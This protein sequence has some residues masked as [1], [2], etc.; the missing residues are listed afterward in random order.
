MPAP[1][2]YGHP[3]AE[4]DQLRRQLQELDGHDRDNLR[5]YRQIQQQLRE[6]DAQMETLGRK[7]AALNVSLSRV[8]GVGEKLR[9]SMSEVRSR[10]VS[11]ERSGTVR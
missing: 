10:I 9:T 7:R 1:I 6:V 8:R 11:I 5:D 2:P 3:R 4:L